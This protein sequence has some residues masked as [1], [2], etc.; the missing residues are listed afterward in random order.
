MVNQFQVSFSQEDL[1]CYKE[2]YCRMYSTVNPRPERG[3]FIV[4]T[5]GVDEIADVNVASDGNWEVYLRQVVTDCQHGDIIVVHDK[6]R[7]YRCEFVNDSE[8]KN[9][10]LFIFRKVSL[11]T[12]VNMIHTLENQLQEMEKK[13]QV[14]MSDLAGHV[15]DLIN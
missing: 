8:S 4:R 13:L 7:L 12:V 9:N 3:Q 1:C 15:N 14:K 5:H 6:D 11:L 2:G 10:G